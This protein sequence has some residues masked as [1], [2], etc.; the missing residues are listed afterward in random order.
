MINDNTRLWL[1]SLLEMQVPQRHMKTNM[2]ISAENFDYSLEEPPSR[3]SI[4]AV[5]E[6]M[7]V[8]VRHHPPA[9]PPA[10]QQYD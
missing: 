9:R 6:E 3:Q 7:G 10:R 1:S 8:I 5:L 2:K 4:Q